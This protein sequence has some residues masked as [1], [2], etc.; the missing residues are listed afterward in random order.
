MKIHHVLLLVGVLGLVAC[1][2]EALD[3]L[4]PEEGIETT[5]QPQ[6][7]LEGG[8]SQVFRDLHGA[9]KD[10]E[11]YFNDPRNYDSNGNYKGGNAYYYSVPSMDVYRQTY[12]DYRQG[13]APQLMPYQ[14]GKGVITG[15]P[16][17]RLFSEEYRCCFFAQLPARMKALIVKGE[18]GKNEVIAVNEFKK[19]RASSQTRLNNAIKTLKASVYGKD[20]IVAYGLKYMNAVQINNVRAGKYLGS[21]SHYSIKDDIVY[22]NGADLDAYAYHVVLHEAIMLAVRE[23]GRRKDI[24]PAL[25]QAASRMNKTYFS[26]YD[27]Y[28]GMV[29]GARVSDGDALNLYDNGQLGAYKA[30]ALGY[31]AS[32]AYN[33]WLENKAGA[34]TLTFLKKIRAN[35][36]ISMIEFIGTSKYGDTVKF[37]KN[38]HLIHE[39]ASDS[40]VQA[41]FDTYLMEASEPRRAVINPIFSALRSALKGKCNGETCASE[42]PS[43]TAAD[44]IR[45]RRPIP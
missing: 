29:G 17:E 9:Q 38:L 23:A 3:A 11:K 45:L 24:T 7:T 39:N 6:S 13:R 37:T 30:F 25:R 4:T 41:Y 5:E 8:N 43:L 14:Q 21:P 44:F 22:I 34:S 19:Q 2:P 1:G 28:I 35:P 18:G 10:M 12:E 40:K 27:G 26:S 32:L 42:P 16:N 20:P 15:E 31:H 33:S 36:K